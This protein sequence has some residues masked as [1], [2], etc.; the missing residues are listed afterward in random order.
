[1]LA[2][3]E[4]E[5]ESA[6]GHLNVVLTLSDDV[7]DPELVAI[8]HYW[9]ARCQRRRG[10]YDH[11]LKHATKGRDLALQCGQSSMAAVMRVLESC[12]WTKVNWIWRA[13][14]RTLPTFAARG[15]RL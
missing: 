10:E 1:M 15:S 11:A 6:T 13:S 8:A 7:N 4:E 9:M 5:A 14:K 3:S 12:T 2:M